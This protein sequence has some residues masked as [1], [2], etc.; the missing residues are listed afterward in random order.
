[1]VFLINKFTISVHNHDCVSVILIR[2]YWH[3]K[4]SI[5]HFLGQ[6]HV[7]DILCVPIKFAQRL[8]NA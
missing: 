7:Q 3:L 4:L 2:S 1:M 5:R 6:L 8:E